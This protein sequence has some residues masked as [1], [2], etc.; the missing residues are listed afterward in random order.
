MSVAIAPPELTDRRI[1]VGGT[2]IRILCGG[3]RTPG[4]AMVVLEAGNRNGSDTWSRVQPAIAE[5]AR[6]CAYD[7]PTLGRV[8]GVKPPPPTPDAVVATLDGLLEGAGERGPYVLVGHSAGGMIV[9]L[10]ATQHPDRVAGMVLI[11]SSHEDQE[12]RFAELN[13]AQA[14]GPPPPGALEAFDVSAMVEALSAAPWRASIQL[15]VLTRGIPMPSADQ[16]ALWLELQRELASR[17][18]RGEHVIAKQSE[19]FIQID[20]PQLVI[21]GVRRMLSQ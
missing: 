19:H 7:R 2:P 15:L 11:D 17:S 20:E 13:P 4:S 1:D 9:R 8:T 10:F 6:V 12:Y 18:P 21:D 3:A 16:Y 14:A 5:F